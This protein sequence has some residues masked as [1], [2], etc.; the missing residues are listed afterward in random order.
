MT[1]STVAL[2]SASQVAQ[3]P[4]ISAARWPIARFTISR[5]G[6]DKPDQS[7]RES[8]PRFPED[9]ESGVGGADRDDDRSVRF[10]PGGGAQPRE[11]CEL[12]L[13]VALAM[14]PLITQVLR[15]PPSR[16]GNGCRCPASL[17]RRCS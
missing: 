1:N 15:L 13:V 3:P 14:A 7:K 5:G 6:I 2:L 9:R 16:W 11:P 4:R 8:P 12:G 10:T 17:D